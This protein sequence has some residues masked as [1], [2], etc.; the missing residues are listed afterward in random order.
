MQNNII[1]LLKH[2]TQQ[3]VQLAL[4]DQQQLVSLSSKEAVTPALGQ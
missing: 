1:G 4:N 2:L 3:G